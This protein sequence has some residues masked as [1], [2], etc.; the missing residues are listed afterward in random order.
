MLGVDTAVTPQE[1][2]NS[3]PQPHRIISAHEKGISG[4]SFLPDGRRIVTGSHDRTLRIWNMENGKQEGASMMVGRKICRL[5]VTQDG[6]RILSVDRGGK[7]K[8]WHVGSRELVHEWIQS[9]GSL[10]IAISQ[11]D[12]LVAVPGGETVG[13]YT[14]GGRQVGSINVSVCFVCFSPDGE[15]LACSGLNSI[16]VY[17]IED[18]TLLGVLR[19]RRDGI[20]CPPLWSRDGSR[21]FSS[22]LDNTIRC[23]DSTTGE[24][25]GQPWRVRWKVFAS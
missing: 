20:S 3:G 16:S 21:L 11:D 23:W 12:R 6:R 7:V 1:I 17:H 15:K 10:S 2:I 19:D 5:A 22:S 13:I 8:V 9:T 18:G 14:L 4:I 25:I 24:Q